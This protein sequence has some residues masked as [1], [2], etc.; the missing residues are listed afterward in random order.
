MKILRI[1]FPKLTDKINEY[2]EGIQVI[3]LGNTPQNLTERFP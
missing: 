1:H 2:P 3:E